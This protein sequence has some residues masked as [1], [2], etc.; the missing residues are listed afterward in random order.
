MKILVPTSLADI[1]LSQY[2]NYLQF[3]DLNQSEDFLMIKRIEIFC[4]LSNEDVMNFQFNSIVDISQ[5]IYEVLNSQNEFIE[6]VTINGIDFGFIPKL[7]DMN[8]GEFLDLNNNISDWENIHIAMGVLYRPIVKRYK[9][10]YTIEEYQGD[11]YH[12]Y[13]KDITMDAV[14]GAMVFFWNLGKDLAESTLKYLEQEANKM[15]FQTQLTLLENGVGTQQL[16]TSLGEI[17]QKTKV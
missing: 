12:S 10:L 1:T 15:N 11:K 2:R 8:Y 7:D 3:V 13:I 17:L 6:K 4:N 5:K 16:T 9:N 14:V